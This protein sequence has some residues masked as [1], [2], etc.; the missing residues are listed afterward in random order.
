MADELDLDSGQ[1]KNSAY[2]N[3]L[4]RFALV[5][6]RF[7]QQMHVSSFYEFVERFDVA[8]KCTKRHDPAIPRITPQVYCSS[9]MGFGA[10]P[11]LV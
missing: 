6:Q 10:V 8:G 5:A 4:D 11:R 3:Y 7:Q 9:K 1:T 2:K